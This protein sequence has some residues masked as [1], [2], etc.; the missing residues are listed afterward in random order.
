MSELKQKWFELFTPFHSR[1]DLDQFVAQMAEKLNIK[2]SFLV[3]AAAWDDTIKVFYKD[4][5]I[6]TG[7][8]PDTVTIASGHRSGVVV[9]KKVMEPT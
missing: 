9:F 6:N 7:I 2:P 5:K 3:P 8:E 4:S 1:A